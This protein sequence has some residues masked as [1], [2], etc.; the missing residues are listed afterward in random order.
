VAALRV[1]DQQ[2]SERHARIRALKETTNRFELGTFAA[3]RSSNQ[4]SPDETSR[5]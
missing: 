4:N 2:R 1:K 3:D 5:I